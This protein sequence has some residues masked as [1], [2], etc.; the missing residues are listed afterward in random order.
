MGTGLIIPSYKSG[1]ARS[2]AEAANPGLWDR[3][4]GLWVPNLGVTAVT[5]WRNIVTPGL[6]DAV[7]SAGF[8]ANQWEISRYG[9]TAHFASDAEAIAPVALPSGQSTMAVYLSKY[10]HTNFDGI[11]SWE[12][13]GDNGVEFLTFDDSGE[14]GL[15]TRIG[16]GTNTSI[17]ASGLAVGSPHLLVATISNANNG[18]ATFWVDGVLIGSDATCGDVRGATQFTMGRS[19]S[20]SAR[21]TNI[22]LLW[23]GVW[24]RVL[25]PDEIKTLYQVP[26]A[27]VRPVQRVR[28]GA[29]GGA[30]PANAP[31]GTLYGSLV[32]PL[33]GAI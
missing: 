2:A 33:G 27:I 14:I 30:P 28:T 1:F 20:A 4:Q 6:Y 15:L 8:T 17:Q 18:T 10:V 13:D 11:A 16:G 32:G 23:G 5:P 9:W 31:T 24:D 25:T 21:R 26:S 29:S 19:R 12:E 3:L 7:V 22:N